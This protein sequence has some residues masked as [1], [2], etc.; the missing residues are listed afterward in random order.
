MTL[1]NLRHTIAFRVFT[2]AV[3]LNFSTFQNVYGQE[4][5]QIQQESPHLYTPVLNIDGTQPVDS[6]QGLEEK[7]SPPSIDLVPMGRG[8]TGRLP[9]GSRSDAS[10]RMLSFSWTAP[11]ESKRRQSPHV[12]HYDVRR[13]TV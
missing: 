5:Y 2:L 11:Q 3:F 8:A 10:K 7:L 4:A 1:S 6:D 13:L 12:D 9:G